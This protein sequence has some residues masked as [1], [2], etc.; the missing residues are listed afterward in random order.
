MIIGT[1]VGA[2]VYSL[3]IPAMV[4]VIDA[5]ASAVGGLV[6]LSSAWPTQNL[7][8]RLKNSYFGVNLAAGFRIIFRDSQLRKLQLSFAVSNFAAGLRLLVAIVFVVSLPGA[9][10]PEEYLS[11]SNI[12][13]GMEAHIRGK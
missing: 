10:S 4:F 6:V 11:T 5:V 9:N 7:T 2:L 1:I 8:H 12:T 13:S 3:S